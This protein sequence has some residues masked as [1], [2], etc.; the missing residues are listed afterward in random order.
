MTASLRR[1]LE[2][3]R[4]QQGS[5]TPRGVVAASRAEDAPLHARFTWDDSVAGER[6]REVEARELIRSVMVVYKDTGRG[7]ASVRGY[8]SIPAT[9][10]VPR[11]Y[12]PTAEALEDP[13]TRELLMMEARRELKAHQ[14]RFGHLREYAALVE[15]HLKEV[16]SA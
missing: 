14:L 12:K 5:L 8:V 3:I 1:A 16:Q 4:R 10:E 2:D 13:L 11:E 7:P 6:W 15:A 9:D